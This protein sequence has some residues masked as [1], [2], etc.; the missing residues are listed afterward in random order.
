MGLGR[1]VQRCAE[2]V[3]EGLV[4]G[5]AGLV[6]GFVQAVESE[7]AKTAVTVLANILFEPTDLSITSR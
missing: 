2:R 7:Q 6:Q 5:K 3:R 4:Q 1:F